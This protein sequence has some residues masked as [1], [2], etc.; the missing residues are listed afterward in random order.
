MTTE[1]GQSRAPAPWRVGDRPSA[2]SMFPIRAADDR[3]VAY[4]YRREIA[5]RI[6]DLV[7]TTAHLTVGRH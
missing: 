4:A 5:E 1:A 7:N 6:V 3:V 2:R